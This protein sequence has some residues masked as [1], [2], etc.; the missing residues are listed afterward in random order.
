MDVIEGKNSGISVVRG[1]EAH[2]SLYM[3]PRHENPNNNQPKSVPNIVGIVEP[4]HL[5]GSKPFSEAKKRGRP[6]KYGP[7]G[8]PRSTLSPTPISA[9]IPLTG[10]VGDFSG[11]KQSKAKPVQTVKK[12]QKAEFQNLG[13]RVSYS[14]GANFTPHLMTV[15]AGED[16]SLKILSFSRQDSRAICILSASGSISS[17]TLRQP[18]CAGGTTT[19]EGRFQILSLSGSFTPTDDGVVKGRSG[20]ISVLLSGP[21][22]RVLGGGLA[23][24]LVAASPVQV[25]LG[26]FLHGHHQEHKPKK[27]RTIDTVD[28]VI[29]AVVNPLQGGGYGI[30]RENLA[31]PPPYLANNLPSLNSAQVPRNIEGDNNAST[32]ERDSDSDS[33]SDDDDINI[34]FDND[35]DSPLNLEIS[36]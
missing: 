9:K 6:R 24:I 34:D 21:D 17:V 3:S 22:G 7:E 31:S 35:N 1:N 33:D 32:S 8:A 11:L 27:Q 29:P 15:N 23:G 14:G 28:P 4:V 20:G 10:G 16:V 25:V 19:Y 30:Q 26:S 13:D 2:Q 36:G 5:P 18:S 12:A